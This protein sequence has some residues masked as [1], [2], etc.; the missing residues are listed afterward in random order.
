M[1]TPAIIVF[2]FTAISLQAQNIG[3]GTVTPHASAQ[4][5]VNSNNK[6][7]LVPRMDSAQ[8]TNIA[9]PATGL[10]V[11]QTN[12]ETPGFYYYTGSGWVA[13][14][15]Q[16]TGW[17]TKGNTGTNRNVNFIGTTDTMDLVIKVNNQLSG[18][19]EYRAGVTVPTTSFGYM[20]FVNKSPL[21]GNNAAFGYQIMQNTIGGFNTGMGV[22]AL[23]ANGNGSQNV[24]MGYKSLHSNTDGNR[25]TGL[26]AYSGY[27]N[28]TGSDNVILGYSAMYGDTLALNMG[29]F[30]VAV[31]S[32]ALAWNRAA[33]GNTAIGYRSMFNN[34]RGIT[35]GVVP[36]EGN[37]AVGQFSLMNNRSGFYNVALGR[38]ALMN[39]Q[40]G[41]NNIAV[42]PAAM[43]E[44]IT[45]NFNIAIGP[46][47]LY[48]NTYGQTNI[49]IGSSAALNNRGGVANTALGLSAL[50][51]NRDG[52]LNL[53]LGVYALYTDTATS[54]QIAIGSYSLFNNQLGQN[55]MAIGDS[56]LYDNSLNFLFSYEASRNTA[57]G[58]KALTKNQYGYNNTALG[59]KAGFNNLEGF[60]NTFLGDSA[61]HAISNPFNVTVIGAGAVATGNN[62]VLLG[63]TAVSRVES[64]GGFFTISDGRFKK[65]V[66]ANVPGLTFINQL[67][68]VTYQL[69]WNQYEQ[70][71]GISNP[72]RY[73]RS[74][75]KVSE[76]NGALQTGFIAQEVLRAANTLGYSF[77]GVAVAENTGDNYSINYAAFV[78]SLVK[79]VQELDA[80][81]K[82]LQNE[83]RKLKAEVEKIKA[84]LGMN[85]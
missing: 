21:S 30:N 34:T 5:D 17:G 57:I 29:S 36:A 48:L 3:I 1:K 72:V 73:N 56:A 15:A 76:P 10:L 6:G 46:Q 49:A 14:T 26:G 68:P 50:S 13:L 41:Y 32:E 4:L 43:F 22:Q 44:N 52:Q 75:Q 63:N 61:R 82:Q 16:T 20:N 53:A 37:T 12:G 71:T 78:P 33:G 70:I 62:K 28:T 42:G 69:D 51:G 66:Q 2:L 54:N 80:A 58:L 84:K 85:D 83:N 67:Q 19:I 24:G 39:N 55:N 8:R 27:Y 60:D 23:Y 47:S 77:S 59:Y 40:S 31:G 11:Y 81:N 79:A 18:L 74:G 65:N 64:Y 35:E 9:T 45:G 25:N 38:W 7:L